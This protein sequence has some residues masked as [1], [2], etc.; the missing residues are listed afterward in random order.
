MRGAGRRYPAR[1]RFN[2]IDS[3]VEL[4]DQRIVALKRVEPAEPYLADHF[5]TYPVL[6][7][8]LMLETMVQAARR[9]LARR[10]PRFARHVIGSVRALKYRAMIHPGQTLVVDVTLVKEPGEGVYEFKGVGRVRTSDD[11]EDPQAAVSG[12]FT[13]RPMRT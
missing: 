9:L 3:V 1:V 10:D 7:G 13:L 2:F 4:N 8:V 11:D 5:P 12:R 6:P